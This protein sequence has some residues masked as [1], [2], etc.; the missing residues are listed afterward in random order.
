MEMRG[1]EGMIGFE[2]LIG[3]EGMIGNEGKIRHEGMKMKIFFCLPKFLD[4]KSKSDD[5]S[6][7]HK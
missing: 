4:L 3:F 2:G 6:Q 1:K 7:F 5:R